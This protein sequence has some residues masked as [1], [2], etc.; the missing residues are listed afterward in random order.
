MYIYV[1]PARR[2]V[3]I[4]KM[5]NDEKKTVGKTV[6]RTCSMFNGNSDLP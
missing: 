4:C 1:K 6:K 2:K 3:S 5:A